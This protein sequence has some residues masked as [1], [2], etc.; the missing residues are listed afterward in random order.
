MRALVLHI[1]YVDIYNKRPNH[2]QG[3]W[4]G[5]SGNNQRLNP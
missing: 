2:C 3:A 5:T 4:G 1:A